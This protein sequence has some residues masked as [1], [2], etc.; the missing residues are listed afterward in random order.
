M[1][2]FWNYILDDILQL[3]RYVSPLDNKTKCSKKSYSRELSTLK[4]NY[5]IIETVEDCLF[6]NSNFLVEHERMIGHETEYRFLELMEKIN[7]VG[8]KYLSVEERQFLE[9]S[10][11]KNNAPHSGT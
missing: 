5:Y 3:K 6:S 7:S 11:C 1:H 4:K 10:Q 2:R 8:E 9:N